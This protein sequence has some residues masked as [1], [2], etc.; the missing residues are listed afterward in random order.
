MQR[1]LYLQDI[2]DCLILV[3]TQNFIFLYF[4]VKKAQLIKFYRPYSPY[5]EG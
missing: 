1:K 5:N 2:S 4:S 3:K